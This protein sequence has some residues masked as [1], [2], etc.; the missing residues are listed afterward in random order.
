MPVGTHQN[1]DR[2]EFDDDESVLVFPGTLGGVE[3]QM[4]YSEEYNVLI[5]PIVELGSTYVGT[6]FDPDAPFDFTQGTGLLTALNPV[7]G[8]ILW[9]VELAT[10]P[11][12]A[13]TICNDVVFSAGLDGVL[14]GFDV[15][16]GTEVFR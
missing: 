1:D 12:A 15:T 5:C 9:E 13:A 7:D 2:R 8:S 11:Y 10:P 6:G 4:A 14:L 16:D 3:T